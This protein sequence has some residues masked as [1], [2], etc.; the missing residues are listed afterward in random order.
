MST[1]IQVS[2]VILPPSK[3]FPVKAPTKK[4]ARIGSDSHLAKKEK[5]ALPFKPVQVYFNG[6]DIPPKVL[7]SRIVSW[8]DSYCLL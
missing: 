4:R 6:G 1:S 7:A 5:G 3:P 8:L 2:N